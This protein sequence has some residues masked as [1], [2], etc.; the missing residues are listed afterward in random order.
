MN[1]TVSTTAGV[2]LAAGRGRRMGRLK[3][4][5]PWGN[6]TVVAAAFDALAPHCGAGMVVVLG[7]EAERI[8]GALAGRT[9]QSV[10]GDSDAEQIDSARRGLGCAV[11]IPGGQRVLLH[12]ADQ[13]IIP[14]SVVE[15]LLRRAC[16]SRR[17]L[18]PT[19]RGRG[20]HPVLIPTGIVKAIISSEPDLTARGLR[21]YWESHPDQ[22]ERIEFPDAS[23]LIMDLDS[24]DDYAAAQEPR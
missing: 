17:V 13:P 12:P 4:L 20:G 9:F 21:A 11:G 18:I 5:L 7:E 24:P 22:V 3:Q 16:E 10:E 8:M 14:P 2:L 6:S 19:H 23:D 1:E 15:A